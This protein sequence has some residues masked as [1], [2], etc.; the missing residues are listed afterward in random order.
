MAGFVK[1]RVYTCL[2]CLPLRFWAVLQNERKSWLKFNKNAKQGLPQ[3][4]ENPDLPR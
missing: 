3:G 4:R 1:I 2:K